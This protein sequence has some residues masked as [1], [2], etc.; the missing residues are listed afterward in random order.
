[1]I[2]YSKDIINYDL[3]KFFLEN[4]KLFY[5][6]FLGYISEEQEF[7]IDINYISEEQGFD[8]D[9]QKLELNEL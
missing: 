2:H 4:L 6:N 5:Y 9:I 8:I 1:M 3:L 7:D